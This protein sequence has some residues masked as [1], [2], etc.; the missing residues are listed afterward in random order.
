M[1]NSFKVCLANRKHFAQNESNEQPQM[2]LVVNE[3]GKVH[4]E[5]RFSGYQNLERLEKRL[6]SHLMHS[7]EISPQKKKLFV[8]KKV[9]KKLN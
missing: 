3:K 8:E 4:F 5:E 7:S 6:V 2:S 1:N 9:R